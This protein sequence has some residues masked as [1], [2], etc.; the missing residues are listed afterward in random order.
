MRP[1][2]PRQLQARGGAGCTSNDL[3]LCSLIL[4][5]PLLFRNHQESPWEGFHTLPKTSCAADS[6]SWNN[7]RGMAFGTRYLAQDRP[8]LSVW[9]SSSHSP[10]PGSTSS[11]VLC[12]APSQGC[13]EKQWQSIHA[14]SRLPINRVFSMDEDDLWLLFINLRESP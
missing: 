4:L 10:S 13:T 6:A 5:L 8:F 14:H 12:K 1:R 3:V 9:P 11:S 7:G 2:V